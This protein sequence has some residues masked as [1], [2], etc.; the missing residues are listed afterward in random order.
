MSA[1]RGAVGVARGRRQAGDDGFE[2]VLDALA[3]LRR[4]QH[5]AEGVEAE[6]VL[7]L[8]LHPLDVGR[9]QIDLVDHRHHLEVVLEGEVEV[10]HGLRLDA[11]R[12]VDQQQRALAGHQ[13]APHLVREVHVPGGVDQVQLGRSGR[14]EPGSSR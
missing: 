8:L 5:G 12:G 1:C 10:G 7:D 14:P 4:A 11:L 2:H 13:R 9:R 3:R 6:V